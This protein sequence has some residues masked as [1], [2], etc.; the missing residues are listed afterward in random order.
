M[1]FP[2]RR[3]LRY[4]G[5]GVLVVLGLAALVVGGVVWIG[6]SRLA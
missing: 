5:I 1:A 3:V 2:V 4:V 6:G